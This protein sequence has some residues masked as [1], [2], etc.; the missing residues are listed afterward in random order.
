MDDC[1][2]RGT[3]PRRRTFLA[4]GQDIKNLDTEGSEVSEGSEDTVRHLLR[5]TRFQPPAARAPTLIEEQANVQIRTSQLRQDCEVCTG[6]S[7]FP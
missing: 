6:V 5:R 4:Q 2:R 3:Q 7:E 1:F